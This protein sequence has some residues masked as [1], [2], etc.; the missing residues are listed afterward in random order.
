LRKT[1]PRTIEATWR[2][3]GKL[4]GHFTPAECA[5]ISSMPVMLQPNR[6]VL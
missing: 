3:I 1:D 6:I 2:G 4:L 5:I